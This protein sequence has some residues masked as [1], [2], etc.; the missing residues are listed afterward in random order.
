MKTR[1]FRARINRTLTRVV[2][3]KAK[4]LWDAEV[5]AKRIAGNDEEVGSIEELT[6]STESSEPEK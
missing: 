1:R 2:E 4:D 3:Y 5:I 6:V